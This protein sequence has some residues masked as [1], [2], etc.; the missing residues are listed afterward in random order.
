MD[1]KSLVSLACDIGIIDWQLARHRCPWPSTQ[2]DATRSVTSLTYSSV[3]V[4]QSIIL[5]TNTQDPLTDKH[6]IGTSIYDRHRWAVE[7]CSISTH[8]Y[9]YIYIYIYISWYIYIYCELDGLHHRCLFYFLSQSI[10]L[11]RHPFWWRQSHYVWRHTACLYI[12]SLSYRKRPPGCVPNTGDAAEAYKQTVKL[13]ACAS[14][15]WRH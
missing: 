8:I 9:I 3:S 5:Y 1:W 7:Q 10:T 6:V 2:L 11:A 13:P 12:S 4:I 14:A 15:E